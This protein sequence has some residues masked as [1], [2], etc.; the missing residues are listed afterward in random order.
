MSPATAMLQVLTVLT[1][2]VLGVHADT[3]WISTPFNPPS[4]PLAVRSPYLS[5]WMNQGPNGTALNDDWPKFWTGNIVGWAGYIK[6]D[7]ITYLFLG[8][9]NLPDT[10]KAVQKSMEFTS[11]RSTFILTA[12]PVELTAEFLSPIEPHDFVMQSFPFSYLT[13]TT[14]SNDGKPHFVQLYTDMTAEW[15]TSNTN[16]LVN[17]TTSVNNG[18]THQVQVQ[19]QTQF[20]EVDSRIQQGSAYYATTQVTGLTWQSGSDVTVRG[21]FISYGVLQNTQDTKFRAVG[22]S[23]PVFAFAHDL[24]NVAQSSP[25]TVA[26]GHVRDPAIQYSVADP[27][28]K[29]QS[30]YF[31]SKFALISNAISFFLNDYPSAISRARQLDSKIQN[32]ASAIS[33]DYAAIAALSARQVLMSTEITLP[34]QSDGKWNISEPRMWLRA[35]DVDTVDNIYPA[36][37]F[38]LYMNATYGKALLLPLLEYGMSGQYPSQWAVHDLGGPYP[39]VNGHNDGK[40][41][42]MPVEETANMLIMALSYTQ[43]TNDTSLITTYFG[44]LDQWAQYLVSNTL[45]PTNQFSTDNFAGSL[46][47]QTNLAV[48]GVLAIKAMSSIATLAGQSEKAASYESTASS[49]ISEWQQLAVSTDQKHLTLNYGNDSSWVLAY[50]LYADKL[51]GTNLIP[52][53]VYNMQTAW[54]GSVSNSFGVPLDTRNTY[55]LS[56]K[57]WQIW[58][59][60]TVTDPIVRDLFITNL[61]KYITDGQSSAP[62]SDW[63]DTVQG[64]PNGFPARAVVGGHFAL[65]TLSN[66]TPASGN[67]VPNSG[68]LTPQGTNGTSSSAVATASKVTVALG[69]SMVLQATVLLI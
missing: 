24:G 16:Q 25:V 63:Y 40:D 69:F 39:Q 49:Y 1:V 60:A 28:L 5:A 22:D 51:L 42:E 11:T 19:Q 43:R 23:W 48:K 2:L 21:E 54:Y 50:N 35:G 14:S 33:T 61:K 45:T 29:I 32:D 31:W 58:S 30:S 62:L 46:A 64:K 20:T 59:A 13:L 67:G 37:P 52:K 3:S 38:F 57:R 27:T 18:I 6:V 65:L 56:G 4:I 12:G 68:T 10:Q 34:K 44:L 9:P 15:T 36:W 17:W 47:N 26:I 55:V 8:A 41:T 7:N 66:S 53:E